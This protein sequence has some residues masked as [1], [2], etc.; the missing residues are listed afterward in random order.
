MTSCSIEHVE[1][2]NH[3]ETL[4]PIVSISYSVRHAYSSRPCAIL[5]EGHASFFSLP[6]LLLHGGSCNKRLLCVTL[7]LLC[8]EQNA[9]SQRQRNCSNSIISQRRIGR[10]RFCA[11]RR[12][13][14][15]VCNSACH[16]T[17]QRKA[18]VIACCSYLA[19]ADS[20]CRRMRSRRAASTFL[21]SYTGS[22]TLIG[23]INRASYS[24]CV[25]RLPAD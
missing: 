5:R 22:S 7:K 11:R 15:A 20:L 14:C 4:V 8:C 18:G 12:S 17:V 9:G 1:S 25:C 23:Y 19:S 24:G 2:L 3:G 13:S 16:C 6:S 21:S 10:F